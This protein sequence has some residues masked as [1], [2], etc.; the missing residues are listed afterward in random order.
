MDNESLNKLITLV[1]FLK[2]LGEVSFN[3]MTSYDFDQ[4]CNAFI[5]SIKRQQREEINQEHMLDILQDEVD[6]FGQG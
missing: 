4:T 5:E 1:E 6:P 3:E 2:R